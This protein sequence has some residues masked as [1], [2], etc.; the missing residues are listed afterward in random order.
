MITA[1]L[2][3]LKWMLETKH[4][5]VATSQVPKWFK[6]AARIHAADTFGDQKEECIQNKSDKMLNLAILDADRLYWEVDTPNPNPPK[7]KKVKVNDKLVMDSV[8]TVQTSVSSVRTQ[9]MSAQQRNAT[10]TTPTKNTSASDTQ[11]VVSQVSTI[12]QLMEQ[13]S[14]LQLA[15]NKINSKLDRLAKFIMAQLANNK[16]PSPLK[17]KAVRGLHGSPGK[18]L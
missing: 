11:M 7:C 6:P 9:K 13:V 4:G 5:K 12:T 17:C 10:E 1:L 3:Y 8:S 16:T 14:I 2:P 15:H 18:A